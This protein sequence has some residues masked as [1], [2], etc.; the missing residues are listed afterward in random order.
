M[1]INILKIFA[2]IICVFIFVLSCVCCVL[3]DAE[4]DDWGSFSAETKQYSYDSSYY[5]IQNVE[6]GIISICVYTMN[7]DELVFEI[8]PCRSSDYLGMVWENGRNAF[9]IQSGDIGVLCYEFE[10]DEWCLNTDR[11][12]PEEIVSR[13]DSLIQK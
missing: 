3:N 1:K 7:D 8:E 10:N 11:E 9:W 5:S 6:N 12:K 4:N 2:I 13:Y